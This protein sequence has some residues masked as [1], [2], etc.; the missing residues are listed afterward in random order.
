MKLRLPYNKA[1]YKEVIDDGCLYVDKTEYIEQIEEMLVRDALF[2]RPRRFG[3]SLFLSMLNYYYDIAQKEHF[4]YLFKDTYIGKRPTNQANSYYILNFDFSTID[5]SN[6]TRL[7]ENFNTHIKNMIISFK[8]RYHLNF[9]IEFTDSAGGNLETFLTLINPLIDDNLIILVDEY[10]H[11][12]NDILSDKDYFDD[13]TS[14]D[15]FVRSFYTTI[16][17]Q[18]RLGCIAKVILTGVSAILL[19]S[20][21]SGANNIIN[22]SMYHRFNELFGFTRADILTLMDQLDISD[23]DETLDDLTEK[24]NGYMF[25]KL[26]EGNRV[27]NSNL[28]NYYLSEYIENGKPPA[29]LEGTGIISDEQKITSMLDLYTDTNSREQILTNII[30]NRKIEAGYMTSFKLGY[31]FTEDMFIYLLYYLGV[32]TIDSVRDDGFYFKVPNL[33]TSD[34]FYKT[35]KLYMER[36]YQLNTTFYNETRD[37]IKEF[38]ETKDLSK[39][40]ATF[41]RKFGNIPK[42]GFNDFN[43]N[44]VQVAYY[45]AFLECKMI[46]ARLEETTN[47][48]RADLV[49]KHN[50]NRDIIEFKYLSNNRYTEKEF[51][52]K[53]QDAFNK[54]NQYASGYDG[55]INCYIIFFVGSKCEY[56]EHVN[57]ENNS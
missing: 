30:S 26:A 1:N 33:V 13:I 36:Q 5:A 32:L 18:R 28:V 12:T 45:I 48:G 57:V 20:L 49:L 7:Q 4:D 44:T 17:S 37:A 51:E 14:S 50:H 27:F 15:G 35:L 42:E 6:K 11:F 38:I 23:K 25:S 9:D 29:T 47:N 19:D 55:Q 2:L 22:Y 54:L 21:T 24:Y 53:K 10:D 8:N 31:E 52:K 39:L 46:E 43:E 56:Y 34:V 3:K 16:K 41:E 40:N